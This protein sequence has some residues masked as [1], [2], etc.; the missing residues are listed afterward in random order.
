MFEKCF[1]KQKPI[2]DRNANG[3]S[4]AL[5]GRQLSSMLNHS[6]PLVS[7]VEFVNQASHWT[8]GDALTILASVVQNY[9][10][11]R[12]DARYGYVDDSPLTGSGLILERLGRRSVCIT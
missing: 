5:A 10:P 6:Q 2:K 4:S 1:D 11:H 9:H 12:E 3:S 7:D 8:K